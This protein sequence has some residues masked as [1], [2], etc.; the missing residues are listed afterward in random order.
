MSGPS[1]KWLQSGAF[2]SA[3]KFIFIFLSFR[4]S[5]T[6]LKKNK[7]MDN[8]LKDDRFKHIAKDKRFKIMARSERKF[9]VDNRFKGMFDN[10]NF[11]LKYSV[12]KRGKP[13]NMTTNDNLK[14]FY[15]L[16]DEEEDDDEEADKKDIEKSDVKKVKVKK[17]EE[18]V[19][20]EDDDED[21]EEDEDE[22]ESSSS[23]SSD[24]SD[25]SDEESEVEEEIPWNE[26]DRNVKR[27]ENISHRLALCNMDW[28]R[29]KAVDLFVILN[30][31][32]PTHGVLKSI[33][34]H[35]NDRAYQIWSFLMLILI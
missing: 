30:S 5:K 27:D 15:E 12:D 34:V 18:K 32:K 3:S 19:V 33:K 29:I 21:G 35:K 24:E 9:K 6:H 17:S 22:D 16:S 1:N 28:D 25:D 4:V 10:K 26:M 23:S 20:E 14:K 11:K 8:I 31:F 2:I 7:I 13:I